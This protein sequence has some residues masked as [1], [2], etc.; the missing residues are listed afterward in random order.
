M[1][2]QM[3]I[4]TIQRHAFAASLDTNKA[5]RTRPQLKYNLKQPFYFLT[6]AMRLN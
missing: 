1:Q 3:Q 4:L 6:F 5:Q 2:M